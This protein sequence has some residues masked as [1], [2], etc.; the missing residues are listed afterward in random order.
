MKKYFLFACVAAALVSCTS[1]EYVGEVTGKPVETDAINFKSVTGKVSRA[2]HVGADAAGLLGGRFVVEGTKGA[3]SVA[4]TTVFDNYNVIYGAN[5]ANTTE[6]NT[7]DW[8]YVGK[9]VHKY[10]SD[11]NISAQTVKYWDYSQA[12]YDFIAYSPGTTDFSKIVYEA[13]PE[14]G[15]L[16]ISDITPASATNATN[17]AYK[18]QGTKD[19]LKEFYIADLVTVPKE[20]YNNEVQINF[21][22]LA[23]KV[24]VALY[25]NVPGYSVR[26][27]EFYE[28][29]TADTKIAGDVATLFS[30]S[31]NI[32]N[33][34]TFTVYYPTVNDPSKSDNNKAHVVFTAD[35][36][37]TSTTNAYAAL[38]YVRE[39]ASTLESGKKYLGTT[40]NTATYATSSTDKPYFTVLP[41]ETATALTLRCNYTLV[42]D[43]GSGE[44]IKVWGAT[45]VVPAEYTQWKSNYAYTYIFKI[46][47]N[48]NGATEKLGGT[49]QGLHPI[50]FDAVVTEVEDGIQETITTV[51][52]PSITTYM[53]GVNATAK[54]EYPVSTTDKIYVM[55]N[56]VTD[57]GDNGQLYTIDVTN[58]NADTQLSEATVMDA[59]N[60]GTVDG[61]DVIGRNGIKLTKAD[62]DATIT[63]IPRVDGND[64][65]VAEGSAA[66]FAAT[67]GTYAYVY[68]VSDADD[69]TFNTAVNVATEPT[70][71][72]T[73]YYTNFECTT[74]APSTFA[75]G[76]YYQLIT[77][78]NTTYAVKVIKVAE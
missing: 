48:T 65:T 55:I 67:A 62:S 53:K 43:D 35:A 54:N 50:T 20:N 15:K 76:L 40:S 46:S 51:A 57:L 16:Y 21:R 3:T 37:G 23:S 68:K 27:V 4:T 73:G 44:T 19:M 28:S 72:P 41:N 34:G 47:D 26:D 36:S 63:A 59:L 70:G 2:D 39:Q 8:E 49:V 5:T 10:A 24:R 52:T 31:S 58:M 14:E 13:D 1:D 42:S 75:A 33:S 71:W 11:R 77:N 6:S 66:S 7:A 18:V 74:V 9:F 61:N 56:G 32:N 38:D 78:N 30:S 22:N 64:V 69:T 45:A 12:Q 17:G 29:A 60:I 25:E